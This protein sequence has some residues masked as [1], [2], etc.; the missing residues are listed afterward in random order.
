M[1]NYY[2]GIDLHKDTAFWTLLDEKGKIIF[3]K[4]VPVKEEVVKSEINLLPQQTKAVLEP[5]CSWRLYARTLEEEGV[6]VEIAHPLKTKAIAINRLKNDRV[7][8]EILAQLLRTDFLPKAYFPDQNIEEMKSLVRLRMLF[9]KTQ[10]K[11]KQ[12]LRD[13][14]IRLQNSCPR[15]DV[16]GK[17]AQQ[18]F[19]E[20]SCSENQA[21]RKDLISQIGLILKEKI[22][23]LEIYLKEKYQNNSEIQILTSLPGFGFLTSL[24]LKAEI[25]SFERFSSP[26]KL[27]SWAGLVPSSYD[28]G[29]SIRRGK[30]TRNGSHL[31]RWALYQAA[32]Q[33]KPKDG[34]L[35]QFY[36]RIAQKGSKRK[37][38]VALSRKLLSLSWHLIKK[39]EIY[40]F[41][42]MKDNY[43]V[44]SKR[45]DLVFLLAQRGCPID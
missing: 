33:I 41:N 22:E 31:V 6:K 32:L 34:K 23:S 4:N 24:I 28:S 14:T 40:G 15:R 18:W 9:V 7:D 3:Q 20:L 1:E 42:K 30:I 37:A 8:S 43:P 2:L 16:F 21:F 35:Y 44:K 29:K 25:G 5:T 12:N 19:K 10:T 36:Q 38:R 13:L 11:L 45:L 17:K 27:C 26:D 39:Q